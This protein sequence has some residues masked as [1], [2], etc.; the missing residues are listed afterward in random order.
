MIT[1]NEV[2]WIQ[3]KE[4]MVGLS[5]L[6]VN[7]D[8]ET[9]LFPMERSYTFWREYLNNVVYNNDNNIRNYIEIVI[10]IKYLKMSS[11]NW[12]GSALGRHRRAWMKMI[13]SEVQ[14]QILKALRSARGEGKLGL[15]TTQIAQAVGTYRSRIVANAS[16]L[17][18]RNLLDCQQIGAALV[19]YLTG[20]ER[21]T[22]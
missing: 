6:D 15:T 11:I 3:S 4:I 18:E 9:P 8:L 21:G 17:K 20:K 10:N 5:L 16:V 1:A 14:E 19:W 7:L 22:S 12:N 2:S 13:S